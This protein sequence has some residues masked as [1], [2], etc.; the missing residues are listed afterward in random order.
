MAEGVKDEKQGTAAQS[1]MDS[2]LCEPYSKQLQ[3]HWL[4]NL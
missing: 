2:S 1:F 3:N 4:L